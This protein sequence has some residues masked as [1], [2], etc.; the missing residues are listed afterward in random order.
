MGTIAYSVSCRRDGASTSMQRTGSEGSTA[1]IETRWLDDRPAKPGRR[2]EQM[3]R[4]LGRRYTV[5]RPAMPAH[6]YV[7]AL[8]AFRSLLSR[9]P[10]ISR[11]SICV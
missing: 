1:V 11:L 3:S 7:P 4:I 2:G 8:A 5:A 10:N 9:S 6:S